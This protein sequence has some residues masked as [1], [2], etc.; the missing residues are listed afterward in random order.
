MI[1]RRIFEDIQHGF[2]VDVGAHHPKRFSNTY[3]F[4]K[5]GWSGINIDAMPGSM[6]LFNKIRPRDTNVEAAVDRERK[7]I[8]F[9]IFNEPALNTFD[10]ELGKKRMN[11]KYHVIEERKIITKTLKDIL[12]VNLP[13][14]R[15]INFMSID[16]EGYDIE[17]IQ[18]NDWKLYRPEYIL[19]ESD[20]KNM[21]EVQ[22]NELYKYLLKQNY[23]LFGKSVLTL[24]FKD[25][26]SDGSLVN[27][28][29]V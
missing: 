21:K 5:M 23:I 11:G 3:F 16:V 29:D 1:L 9:Y 10:F 13:K 17:V 25:N 27:V 26:L 22:N 18:S 6:E 4:Y 19:I 12:D 20:G 7:E 8:K 15:K 14:N 28:S 24:I 2:Y